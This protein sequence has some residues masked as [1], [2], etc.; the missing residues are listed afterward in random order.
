[1]L[2]VGLGNPGTEYARTRHNVGFM[3]VDEIVH[4]YSFP[5]F[6]E[7]GKGVF[8]SADIRGQKI[9]ILKPSTFMNLSGE[10][11]LGFCS[12][13]KLTPKDIIV[14]HDD[15]D[16]PVGKVKVKRGGSSGGHNGLKSID[17][18]IGA[19]YLRV[20]I[21]VGHPETKENVVNWVLGTFNAE[22]SHTIQNIISQIA[23]YLPLLLAGEDQ[24]FMNRLNQK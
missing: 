3:A 24:T 8:S 1:M 7:K 17:T 2:L 5:V 10:A 13:Y 22:D 6:R 23:D 4:R 11:V 12:F 9:L 15:M 16:L 14:F 19:D 21:G 20:R 18:H